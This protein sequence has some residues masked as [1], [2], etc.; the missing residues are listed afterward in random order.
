MAAVCPILGHSNI[1]LATMAYFQPLE[2][3]KRKAIEAVP[4]IDEN[5]E[6]TEMYRKRQVIKNAVRQKEEKLSYRHELSV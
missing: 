1:S 5:R 6:A 4:K 2:E 3:A